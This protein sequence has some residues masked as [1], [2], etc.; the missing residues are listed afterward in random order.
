MESSLRSF[1]YL[2]VPIPSSPVHHRSRESQNKY[3]DFHLARDPRRH[4]SFCIASEYPFCLFYSGGGEQGSSRRPCG[5][6]N[7]EEANE[8]TELVSFEQGTL[9]YNITNVYFPKTTM[10][11]VII[12]LKELEHSMLILCTCS[13]TR[14]YLLGSPRASRLLQLQLFLG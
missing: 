8:G 4:N 10:D 12:L 2:R 9:N 1:Q 6:G 5:L 13:T 7:L 11:S 3:K 14:Q